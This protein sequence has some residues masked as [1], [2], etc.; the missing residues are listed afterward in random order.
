MKPT[1]TK[2]STIILAIFLFVVEIEI[3]DSLFPNGG[4]KGIVLLPMIYVICSVIIILGIFLTD[5]MKFKSR[6]AIW[7]IIVV[8]NSLIV[9]FLYPK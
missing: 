2:P 7:L 9:A 6:I 8:I 5:K 4:F 3:M 1:S